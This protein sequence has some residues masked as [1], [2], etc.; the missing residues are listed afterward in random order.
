MQTYMIMDGKTKTGIT[1]TVSI[2]A[3]V[4]LA[5]F[6]IT[7]TPS[8]Y[9]MFQVI[10]VAIVFPIMLLGI[11]M[12]LTGK[13]SSMIAGYNT[14]PSNVKA[15]YNAEA[16]SK[17]VGTVIVVMMIMILALMECIAFWQNLIVI[18]ALAI[19]LIVYTIWALVHINKN[20]KYKNDP[21]KPIPEPTEAEKKRSKNIVIVSVVSAVVIIAAVFGL[22]MFYGDVSADIE[23]DHIT[24]K[25]PMV[26][27]TID[28]ADI[29]AYYIDDNFSVGVRTGGWGSP[30]ILSGNF[31][32][33]AFGSY[34][35]ASYTEVKT[36]IVIEHGGNHLVFNLD[37]VEKTQQAFDDLSNKIIAFN[38]P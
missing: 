21:S 13:G 12:M 29:T 7:E 31:S 3:M 23:D 36:Y 17:A 24:V 4:V 22:I 35:L 38:T 28:Y 9:L 33:D 27:E 37:S 1:L 25:A 6:M 8:D 15:M 34:K 19:V 20:P 16:L 26:N 5:Y 30:K 10:T 32:N 2:L 11:Y 18:A 14:S